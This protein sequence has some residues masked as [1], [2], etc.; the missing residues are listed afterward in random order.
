MKKQQSL[1]IAAVIL[2]VLLVFNLVLFAMQ[3]TDPLLFWLVLAFTALLAY[4]ILP[5]IRKK[6]TEVKK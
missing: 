3:I 5:S 1:K 2:T 4:Y 6:M